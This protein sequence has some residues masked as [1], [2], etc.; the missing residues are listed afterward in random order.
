[1]EEVVEVTEKDEFLRWVSRAEVHKKRLIHRSVHAFVVHPDGR[2]LIQLRHSNKK[3]YPHYWDISCSGHVDRIDHPND[4]P[5]RAREACDLAIKREL[6]EEL[7]VV[8]PATFI[9]DIPPIEGVNY[10]YAR[11]Y[12]VEWD[13]EFV[14]QETEVEQVRWLHIEDIGSIEKITDS[15]KWFVENASLWRK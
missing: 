8:S 14:L 15:L 13:K 4:N 1:M 7:G 2:V 5:N 3:T 11:L 9:A 10:E 6:E 12:I